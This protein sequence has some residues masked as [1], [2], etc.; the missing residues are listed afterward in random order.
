MAPSDASAATAILRQLRPPYRLLVIIEGESL[1]N[2][3]SS[4]LIYRLA[5]MT[6]ASGTP[7]GWTLLPQLL[8]TTGGG[9]LLGWA[10]AR[11]LLV[12]PTRRLDIPIAVLVQFLSTV[13]VWLLADRLGVTGTSSSCPPSASCSELS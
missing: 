11:L 3:A 13:A 6:A 7:V 12:M 8:F 1:L 10:L 4:L 9:G 5:V 2:D